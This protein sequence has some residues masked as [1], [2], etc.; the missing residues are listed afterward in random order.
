VTPDERERGLRAIALGELV[1]RATE[2]HVREIDRLGKQLDAVQRGVH[3]LLR[4]RWLRLLEMIERPVRVFRSGRGTVRHRVGRLARHS[5]QLPQETRCVVFVVQWY[6]NFDQVAGLVTA[7]RA[8]KW[9]VAVVVTPGRDASHADSRQEYLVDEAAETWEAL[10]ARGFDP[11]PAVPPADEAARI[12]SWRPVAVF[13]PSPYDGQ[14]HE[15]M[16]IDNLGLPIHYVNYGFNV[17]RPQRGIEFDEPFFTK[18]AAIYTENDYCT[19]NFALAGVDPARLIPSGPPGLD[20]WDVDHG[21]ADVPTVIWAPHWSVRFHGF[22]GW[23]AGYAT[24]I[25]SYAAVLEEVERRPHVRWL[26]RPHPLLWGELRSEGLWTEEEEA[27][28]HSRVADLPNMTLVGGSRWDQFEQAWAMV[29]D[30]ISFLAE[31]AC[32]GKPLLLMEPPD[33]PGWN[34]VGEAIADAVDRSDGASGLSEFLDRLERDDDPAA[35]RR[36]EVARA[37]FYHPRGGSAAAIVRHLNRV[38]RRH[39]AD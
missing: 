25:S 13:M 6:E 29:T 34:V 12:R 27:R 2:P 28:F 15:S 21:R 17:S 22:D 18:C 9:R 16:S 35:T 38:A 14:R 23:T 30:G 5:A 4:S 11:E 26:F 7:L 31:F 20:H 3:R 33:S 32:T 8:A 19:G 36:R 1:R 37:Q 24:F 10:R 39:D